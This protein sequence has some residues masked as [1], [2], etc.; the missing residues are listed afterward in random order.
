MELMQRLRFETEVSASRRRVWRAL[1]DPEWFSCWAHEFAPG[2]RMAG[3]LEIGARIRFL[4]PDG[5]GMLTRVTALDPERHLE[6]EVTGVI[7]G[8]EIEYATADAVAWK[9]GRE[10]HRLTDCPAGC[11]LGVT[12]DVP[13]THLQYMKGAWP[14]ALAALKELVEAQ[15]EPALK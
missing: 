11:R 8:G 2:S 13:V 9:G 6:F 12:V 3:R 4:T 10:S 5:S 14:R 1:T 7:S 15:S